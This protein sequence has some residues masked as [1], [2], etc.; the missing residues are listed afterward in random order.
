MS[1]DIDGMDEVYGSYHRAGADVVPLA[2]DACACGRPV[3][4]DGRCKK[5]ADEQWGRDQLAS[6]RAS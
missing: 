4:L 5:H 1:P 6:E 2:Y 3:Y